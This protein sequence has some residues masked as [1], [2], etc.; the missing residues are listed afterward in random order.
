MK[1]V[2]I[3]GAMQ[4]EVEELISVMT[5]ERKVEKASMTFFEGTI[6]KTPVVVVKCG[7]GK[8]HAGICMQILADLFSV[9]LVINTG[10]AGS[11]RSEI[12]IG[13]I[14]VSTDALQ[15]DMDV[16]ALGYPLGQIPDM[17]T[18]TYVADDKMAELAMRACEETKLPIKAYRGRV[19]SGDQF[20]SSTEKKDFLVATFDGSCTEMEGA[21]I[22]QAAYLNHVPFLVIR[23]IS[24]KA[25]GSAHMDYPTF[26]KNSAHNSFV[27]VE[28]MLKELSK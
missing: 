5:V 15:H 1:K 22:A 21:S 14:V 6:G 16:T 18:S 12:N 3:I 13:D 4:I 2:G 9:D 27:L 25:D 24:D 8:V 7:I 10:V 19:L 20:V 28:H 23:A 17:E 26:E 11:L